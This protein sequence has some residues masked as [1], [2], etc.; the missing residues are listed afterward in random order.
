MNCFCFIFKSKI[1]FL[2]PSQIN[3]S[4]KCFTQITEFADGFRLVQLTKLTHFLNKPLSFAVKR[5]NGTFPC[6][7]LYPDLQPYTTQLYTILLYTAIHNL[8][9]QLILIKVVFLSSLMKVVF[10]QQK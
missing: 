5:N 3:I 8:T 9:V 10:P 2:E 1:M 7:C 6:D 4:R